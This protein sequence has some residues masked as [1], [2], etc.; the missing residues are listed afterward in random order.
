[1][2]PS[3]K[4]S[5]KPLDINVYTICIDMSYFIF[6][7]YYALTGWWKLA[8]PDDPLGNPIDNLEFVEKFKKTF[9]DKIM[10]IPK[11]LKLANYTFIAGR[12]CPRTD[13]WRHEFYDKYKA[14]RVLDDAFLGGPFFKLSYQLLEQLKIQVLYHPHLEGDDCIAL[15]VKDILET[16][17]DMKIVII[18]NDM[19]YLQ[20]AG[21]RIQ[22][23]N[24]KYKFLTDNKKWSGDPQKDLFCKIVMG[25]KSDGIPAIFKK[26]G[27]K[28]A[29]KYYGDRVAFEAQLK[30]EDAYAL[31]ERN[32]K[33]VDFN[34]I[35]IKGFI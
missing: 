26:C 22:L 30:K 31:Y 27:P 15:K 19:D 33:L 7:R 2:P 3:K 35:P 14:N 18:A 4:T 5:K 34:A 9:V 6:Y 28:T 24:L 16:T 13:I 25:D 32:T 21:P 17:Q 29:L 1:M 11:K 20:L 12:D 8:K 23:I 10:E